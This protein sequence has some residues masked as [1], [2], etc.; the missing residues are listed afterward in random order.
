MDSDKFSDPR[1]RSQRGRGRGGRGRGRGRGVAGGGISRGG[2][3]RGQ[4]VRGG[5]ST[6]MMPAAKETKL[7]NE[8]EIKKLE[9]NAFRFETYDERRFQARRQGTDDD[10][11]ELV[12]DNDDEEDGVD[13]FEGEGKEVDDFVAD[14]GDDDFGVGEEV[15]KKMVIAEFKHLAN[16]LAMAPF[17]ARIGQM[18]LDELVDVTDKGEGEGEEMEVDEIMKDLETLD[19]DLEEDKREGTKEEKKEDSQKGKEAIK[20]NEQSKLDGVVEEDDDFDRWLDDV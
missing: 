8:K 7:R 9:S 20:K 10:A 18:E 11:I 1:T 15:A 17:S 5:S 4:G 13:G 19:L 6:G 16:V 3:G 12:D 14:G 2:R